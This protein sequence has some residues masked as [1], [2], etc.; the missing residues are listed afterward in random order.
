M[1]SLNLDGAVQET[2]VTVRVTVRAETAHA[3][4]GSLTAGD[5]CGDACIGDACNPVVHP[6]GG[7]LRVRFTSCDVDGLPTSHGLPSGTRGDNRRY[8]ARLTYD[9]TRA[10][11]TTR[12]TGGAAG[13]GGGA[14][15]QGGAGGAGGADV[16]EPNLRNV[17]VGNTTSLRWVLV[18]ASSFGPAFR[19]A[20]LGDGLGDGRG[21]SES[22][23]LGHGLGD[24]GAILHASDL[25]I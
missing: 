15:N 24:A 22:N 4:W 25:C 5:A 21:A 6:L 1:S 23:G 16:I 20:Q 2:S 19:A 9:T 3:A 14:G 7:D 13:D 18:N 11:D 10:Y 12:T 8:T 17:T